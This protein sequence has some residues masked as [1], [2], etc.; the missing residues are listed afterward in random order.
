M[1]C[2]KL[3]TELHS[4]LC[5]SSP[6]HFFSPILIALCYIVQP[7]SLCSDITSFP[8]EMIFHLNNLE[9]I[10][11]CIIL[12]SVLP[13]RPFCFQFQF[14]PTIHDFSFIY[15]FW[16]YMFAVCGFEPSSIFCPLYLPF[17]RIVRW[18]QYKRVYEG[19]SFVY[20]YGAGFS[21][22]WVRTA[23]SK[24]EGHSNGRLLK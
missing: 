10:S 9:S 24:G 5:S 6:T 7:I 3:N 2:R 8:V 15:L 18:N 13:L 16:N 17:C 19:V 11:H 12:V 14:E 20:T 22:A 23:D 21:V 4:H 1:Q